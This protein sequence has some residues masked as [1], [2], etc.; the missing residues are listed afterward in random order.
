M[1]AKHLK[2][3]DCR[4][5]AGLP[6]KVDEEALKAALDKVLADIEEALHGSK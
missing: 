3:G 4:T 5:P 6:H 1:A 2:V